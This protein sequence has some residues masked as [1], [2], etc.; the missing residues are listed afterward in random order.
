MPH[1]KGSIEAL[2]KQTFRNF[3]LIIQDGGSTDKT[4]EYLDTIRD[5]PI[6][7]A[8]EKD[9]GFGQAYNRGIKRCRGEFLCLSASDE[10]LL[11]YALQLGV[12]WFRES[13]HAAAHYGAVSLVDRLGVEQSLFVPKPFDLV[14]FMQ[15]ETVPSFAACVLN[16][17]VIGNGLYYDET[18]KMC[19]DYDFWLRLGSRFSGEDIRNRTELFALALADRTST[20]YRAESYPQFCQ[21]KCFILKRYF[22]SNPSLPNPGQLEQEGKEG[23]FTWALRSVLHLDGVSTVARTLFSMQKELCDNA[24]FCGEV[25][26][27]AL[28]YETFPRPHKNFFFS[29]FDFKNKDRIQG[30]GPWIF[31]AKAALP[32]LP[33]HLDPWVKI[34]LQVLKGSVGVCLMNGETIEKERL[35]PP[36]SCIE[37][38]CFSLSNR[39]QPWIL[40]R[41]VG[42]SK[43]VIRIKDISLCKTQKSSRSP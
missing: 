17:K 26:Q 5:L 22:A 24:P 3:E 8:S 6:E 4:L 37:T 27:S 15:C 21:E 13:P 39:V 41:T 7:I 16:R 40:F 1:I 23:I 2:R 10:R 35:L 14:K 12:D 29:L 11:P 34:E 19:P 9:S 33:A 18:L 25:I 43:C 20:T 38:V 36:D 42:I 30:K 32:I 28:A 31:L